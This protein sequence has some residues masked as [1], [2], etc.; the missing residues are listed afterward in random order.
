M[1][2]P[3]ENTAFVAKRGDTLLMRSIEFEMQ[4]EDRNAEEVMVRSEF[5]GIK[6][7]TELEQVVFLLKSGATGFACTS[8]K[9]F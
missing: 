5:K 7:L 8:V 4:Q 3:R 9:T 6:S 2:R 1:F